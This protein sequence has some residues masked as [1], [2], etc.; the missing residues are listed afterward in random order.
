MLRYIFFRLCYGPNE[1][2]DDVMNLDPSENIIQYS[3]KYVPDLTT[4]FEMCIGSK[5]PPGGGKTFRGTRYLSQ[6][7]YSGGRVLV[8][9]PYISLSRTFEDDLIEELD[10]FKKIHN[11]RNKVT[12]NYETDEFEYKCPEDR[13]LQINENI[14]NVKVVHYKDKHKKLNDNEY[15]IVIIQPQ[16]LHLLTNHNFDLVYMDEVKSLRN[17]LAQP[18]HDGNEH[19]NWKRNGEIFS[20]IM[21]NVNHICVL[22]ADFCN[23]DIT[24]LKFF[25]NDIKLI[26]NIKPRE[27]R[28]YRELGVPITTSNLEKHQINL[29]KAKGDKQ[30]KNIQNLIKKGL[31][32]YEQIIELLKNGKKIVM[33]SGSKEVV[34]M[35][36]MSLI[37]SDFIQFNRNTG[38]GDYLIYTSD[39]EKKYKKISRDWAKCKFIGYTSTI[40][41]GVNFNP[42]I[43][44]FDMC[45]LVA[46]ARTAT[47]AQYGQM[48]ERSRKF[49]D[50]LLLL[51]IVNY[52]KVRPDIPIRR[53]DL[54]EWSKNQTNDWYNTFNDKKHK[55]MKPTVPWMCHCVISTFH[56][57]VLSRLFF[58]KGLMRLLGERQYEKDD[59]EMICSELTFR[60]IK[61]IPQL[62]TIVGLSPQQYNIMNIKSCSKYEKFQILKYKF[63]RLLNLTQNHW[64]WI[65]KNQSKLWIMHHHKKYTAKE[66]HNLEI[67]GEIIRPTHNVDI[68]TRISQ[69][70]EL[71]EHVNKNFF[72]VY[73]IKNISR[74]M[75][76]KSLD[77][78]FGKKLKIKHFLSELGLELKAGDRQQE[79]GIY[80]IQKS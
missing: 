46:C 74:D 4:L 3:G 35:M 10:Y 71:I 19:K 33:A 28:R 51:S 55:I 12:F 13:H 30:I 54:I 65:L 39:T 18:T 52:A 2:F 58:K 67:I 16:S 64:K 14:K 29:K 21:R 66:L 36:E 27:K 32:P 68:V 62:N 37:K 43:A 23:D 72:E 6:T 44:H 8:P 70:C 76:E 48:I 45:W 47:I 7:L 5:T 77:E 53:N 40:T 38:Q 73:T 49:K 11:N 42:I 63:N 57:T 31:V 59:E 75:L 41:C 9:T 24:W 22:D 69:T 25:T 20:K 79:G 78:A 26:E 50:N 80:R 15:D 60:Q 1:C 61:T 34:E 56:E 17:A